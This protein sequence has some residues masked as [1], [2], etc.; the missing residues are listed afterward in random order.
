MSHVATSLFYF[1]LIIEVIIVN[2][3]KTV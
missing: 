2:F 1:G 3:F